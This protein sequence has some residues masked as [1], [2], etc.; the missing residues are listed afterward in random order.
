MGEVILI[1]TNKKDVHPNLV[2]EALSVRGVPFLRLNTEAL[3]TDYE[4]EWWADNSG[5]DFRI[6]CIANG[7][8]CRGSQISAVW[9]RRP[10]APT[11]LSHP[12]DPRIDKHNLAEA[13]GFLV[14]LRQYIADIPSIG[15]IKNDRRASSKM[16]QLKLAHELGFSIPD[17]LFANRKTPI[18]DFADRHGTIAIKSIENDNVWLDVDAMEEYVFYTC[19]TEGK[20]LQELPEEAFSQTVSFVQDYVPKAYEL[21]V[22]VVGDKVFACKIDSQSMPGHEGEVD[23]RQGLD[24]GM[25]HVACVLPEEIE[26]KCIEFTRR[27]GLNFGCFDLVVTPS[28]EHVFFGVQSQWTMAL[29][30][31]PHWASHSRSDS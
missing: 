22:T 14:F 13:L 1:V 9:E 20:S 11:E 26:R 31:T 27:M 19:K 30:A 12:G 5:C 4:F 2:E 15:S 24:H 25:R 8:E 28:G 18:A 21:R 23:W 16:L 3:L 7:I 6:L 17:S 29:G 10:E